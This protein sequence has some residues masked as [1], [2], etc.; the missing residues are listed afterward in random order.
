[1]QENPIIPSV[2]PAIGDLLGSEVIHDHCPGVA[3]YRLN[4]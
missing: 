4:P 1:M 2:S 3:L